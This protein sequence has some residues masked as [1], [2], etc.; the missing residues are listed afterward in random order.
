VKVTEYKIAIGSAAP[1][2]EEEVNRLIREGF[3]PYGTPFFST[4]EIQGM[5][6]THGF[7]QAMVKHELSAEAVQTE[8][9]P[10]EQPQPQIPRDL[11]AAKQRTQ[12]ELKR[13]FS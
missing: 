1:E 8:R 6:D 12:D 9:A 10:A 11:E 7:F 13:R 4:W 2:F 5:A 3:Q